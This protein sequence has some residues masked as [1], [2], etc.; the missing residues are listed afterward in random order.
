MLLLE[1]IVV[2]VHHLSILYY[3]SDG[4]VTGMPLA[5]SLSAD[6]GLIASSLSCCLPVGK[7]L[8]TKKVDMSD[9]LPMGGMS[10]LG[11]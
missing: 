9:S 10:A 3:W 6:P 5:H 8:G 2:I 4:V 7:S 1:M 11:S